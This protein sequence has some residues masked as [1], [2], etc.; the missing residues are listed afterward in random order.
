MTT[1]KTNTPAE[2]YAII[3]AML[4]SIVNDETVNPHV[5][6]NASRELRSVIADLESITPTATPKI[7]QLQALK[8]A[9]G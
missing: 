2:S 1:K 3:E 7:V 5:R 9:K 6:V 8:R 4:W